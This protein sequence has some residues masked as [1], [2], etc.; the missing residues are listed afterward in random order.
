MPVKSFEKAYPFGCLWA[1][2]PDK[3]G[4]FSSSKTLHQKLDTAKVM[5][6]VLPTGRTHGMSLCDPQLIT[7]FWSI[8]LAKLDAVKAMGIDAWK[9][10]VLG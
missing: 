3:P 1:S 10:R 9:A 2:L 7:L 6:G 8:E 4:A 5:L